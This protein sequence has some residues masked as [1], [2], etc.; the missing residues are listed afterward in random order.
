MKGDNLSNIAKTTGVALQDILKFN[1]SIEKR[2]SYEGQSLHLKNVAGFTTSMSGLYDNNDS[3]WLES[4]VIEAV[5]TNG[6]GVA[7]QS[8]A[9]FVLEAEMYAAGLSA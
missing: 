6:N 9:K 2:F 8:Q 1:P 7:I 4:F 3:N 5:T